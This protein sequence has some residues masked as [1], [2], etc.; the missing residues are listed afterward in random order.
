VGIID[1]GKL[2]DLGPPKE[3]VEKYGVVNLEDVFVQRT[4]RKLRE[5][6]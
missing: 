1:Q 2:I 4:G 6:V 5:V 3:L